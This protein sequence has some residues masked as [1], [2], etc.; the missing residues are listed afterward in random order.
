LQIRELRFV[1]GRLRRP[2]HQLVL[3][4]LLGRRKQAVR[5]GWRPALHLAF[6]D[7]L[8]GDQRASYQLVLHRLL[9]GRKQTGRS[10]WWQFWFWRAV[11]TG[12]DLLLDQLG[13]YME[14]DQR[15]QYELASRSLLEC[16]RH[17]GGPRPEARLAAGM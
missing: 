7:H 5:R 10:G 4:G 1:V 15:A 11:R 16:W 14:G 17:V 12:P 6:C 2:H 13:G 8:G 3:R 9:G